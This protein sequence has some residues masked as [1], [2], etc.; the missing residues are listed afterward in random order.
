MPLHDKDSVRDLLD[1]D[2]YASVDLS[3]SMPKYRFP[4]SES[5]PRHAYA[6]VHDELMLDGNSRQN[7]ATF[8]QT[9]VEPEVHKLMDEC[10]D[11]NLID[12]DEYPQTAEIE[13]R[14]VHM[15]ADLW[16]SPDSANSIGC[17]TAGSSEAAML[18]GMAM[19][20]RWEAKR[21][22]TSKP[23][24]ITGPVQVCWHKFVRY[25][26]IEHREIPMEEGRLIMTPE[27]VLKRCD[28][29]TIG[30][31]PTLGVTFT[32]QYEPVKAVAD[33]LN[34]L[35][36]EKGWD[37]P[38]HVD[39]ASGGFLAPFC[40][41]NLEW[42]FRLPRVKSINA[43]GHKFGLS[44]LGVGWVIWREE[45]DLPEELIFWVNYLGGNMR[46]IALNFSRPGG[47]VACQYYNFL[48]LGREG[49]QKIHTACYETAQ[50]L[51]REIEKLGP[52]EV[53]YDG[54]M[55]EGI[56]AL[57]WK[58]KDG[59]DLGFSLYDLADRLRARGWQVPAYSLPSDC[60]DVVIQRILVR[61]G[62][63]RDLGNLLLSDMKRAIEHFNAH[64][65]EKS[66]TEK[67]AAGF[68]H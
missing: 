46:D 49:Y 3:V 14:C 25:W 10:I 67:E 44:P 28:E 42:D 48:R 11:K 16:S 19:K 12:K 59:V 45:S 33:A 51:A 30:V 21:Q 50:H 31:V 54:Q 37:I 65:I 27:E 35:Q 68:H 41:P 2:I 34:R 43:S 17:S 8:C 39:G 22:G 9:W 63:S 20:R 40:S 13:A 7:L 15:L 36:K 66:L 23:N 32:C 5:D 24:L 58:V 1:D 6:L 26:D 62:V 60:Q 61:H 29:N 52:F 18:G 64:P 57:C 47:Q 53:I 38:I 55:D 4:S 56:P